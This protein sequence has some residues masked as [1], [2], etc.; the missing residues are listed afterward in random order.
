MRKGKCEEGSCVLRLKMDMKNNNPN[1]RDLIIYRVIYK[2]HLRTG[3]KWCIYPTYDYS[4]CIVDSLEH[5]S[6]SM[7][8]LEFEI[9]RDSYFWLLDTLGLYKPIVWEFSRLN[10]THSVMS[11]RKVNELVARGIV[12]GWDDPRLTSLAGLRRRG[13]CPEILSSFVRHTGITRNENLIRFDQLESCS[14][15]FLDRTARRAMA[16]LDPV[17]VDIE[18]FNEGW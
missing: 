6:H 10:V 2:P 4:H 18:N 15:T 16:V 8:T 11:K 14:R 1:M 13:F 3:D 17:R 9:R 7:C 5:V 12:S